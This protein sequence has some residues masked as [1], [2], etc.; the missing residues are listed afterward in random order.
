MAEHGEPSGRRATS[1]NHGRKRRDDLRGAFIDALHRD[2]TLRGHEEGFP[3]LGDVFRA[4]PRN[5][6]IPVS[7]DVGFWRAATQQVSLTEDRTC[8]PSS[9][10]VAEGRIFERVGEKSAGDG[11]EDGRYAA[12]E[13]GA[14]GVEIH[15]PALE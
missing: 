11:V 13:F 1:Y 3:A 10:N 12:V 6:A 9:G 8:L 15:E 4:G 14:D 2:G 5:I 7:R